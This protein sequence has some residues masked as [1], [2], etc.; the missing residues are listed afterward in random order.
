M[1]GKKRIYTISRRIALPAL[2][3]VVLFVTSIF[4]VILPQLE[5]SFLARKQEM[6]RE[7]VETACSLLA[8]YHNRELSGELSTSEA[9]LRALLRTN[10][11]RYGPEKKDYFWINDMVPQDTLASLSP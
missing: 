5:K 10:E 1:P 7:Q 2:L 11:L 3:T 4:F 6:I 9:Q 8:D